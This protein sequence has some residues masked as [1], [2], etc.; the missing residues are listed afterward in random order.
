MSYK[1][2]DRILFKYC[3]QHFGTITETP[4]THDLDCYDYRVQLDKGLTGVEYSAD[5]QYYAYE[6]ELEPLFQA[7]E[8]GKIT[9]K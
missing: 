1:I 2:G 9:R 7:I 4:D 8:D 3:G 6:Q 5:G